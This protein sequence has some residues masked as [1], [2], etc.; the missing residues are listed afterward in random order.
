MCFPQEFGELD[1][2]SVEPH[3]SQVTHLRPVKVAEVDRWS[4]NKIGMMLR[5]HLLPPVL[6]I[7]VELP[8]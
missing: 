1:C 2:D 8:H 5:L 6:N 3:K 4:H 7:Q